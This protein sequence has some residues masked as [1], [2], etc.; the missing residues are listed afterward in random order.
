MRLW[1]MVALVSLL[2]ASG[3]RGHSF[4]ACAMDG[5]LHFVACCAVGVI[6]DEGPTADEQACCDEHAFT[7]VAPAVGVDVPVPAATT[8]ALLPVSLSPAWPFAMAWPV[9][10][11]VLPEHRGRAGPAPPPRLAVRLARLSVL[12]S[13]AR[14]PGALHLVRHA[15]RVAVRPGTVCSRVRRPSRR[16]GGIMARIPWLFFAVALVA[17]CARGVP[18]RD[19]R[20]V[21]E[22]PRIAQRSLSDAAPREV[23]SD[24]ELA[25]R[26]DRVAV[27]R[28]VVA[29]SP[30]LRA[31]AFRVR[32]MVA[33][34]RASGA[35]PPPMAMATLWQAPLHVPF[36]YGDGSMLM[37]GLSQSF[38]PPAALEAEARAAVEDARGEAAMLAFQ[39]RD[40]VQRT[41][42]LLVDLGEATGKL[43]AL[44][45]QRRLLAQM[46]ETARARM[47]TG[48]TALADVARAQLE[49]AK[50]ERDVAMAR[51]D[52]SR[53]RA[54]L[55]ALLGRPVDAPLADLDELPLETIATSSEEIV[56][57]ARANRAEIAISA[58]NERRE[59]LRAEAA[60]SR[61]SRPE[62]AV[63]VNYGLAR[64]SGMP[65]SWGATF[66]MS[67]PWLSPA[68]RAQEEAATLARSAAHLDGDAARVDLDR[69]IGG[70][71]ARI[72]AA[73]RQLA[74][75]DTVVV[76][77]TQRAIEAT[78]AGYATGGSDV[79][80][81]LDAMRARL[82]T[83]LA[84][85]LV[86]AELA[87]AV[88]DLERAA[89]TE[90]PR[91]TVT[92]KELADVLR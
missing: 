68:Y 52:R 22:D 19:V 87:R 29:R 4:F 63:G 59:S 89:G 14:S 8:V 43:R 20:S 47:S 38:P 40:L 85:V 77:A 2:V 26:L 30:G 50:L 41:D 70:T 90:L 23:V 35:L 17:G 53:A 15:S 27:V 72:D 28:A 79:V 3:L 7:N 6:E 58:S 21:L 36:V 54:E 42:L 57:K 81:W 88:V 44:D 60:A 56:T 37:L 33:G 84:R 9:R 24:A 65:D 73:L 67:L 76:P 91:R 18:E 80:G 49:I 16:C 74:I 12:L 64:Q 32:S 66:S 10:Q 46:A 34:A 39:E 11:A 62:M 83:S 45:D 5:H 25:A 86:R 48:G 31:R 78:R 69:E 71:A 75:L 92:E 55:N 61:A 82:D 13:L 1:A 51:S